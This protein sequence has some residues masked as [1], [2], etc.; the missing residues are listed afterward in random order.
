M[1]QVTGAEA[2]INT[3]KAQGV[4]HIF[5]LPGTTVVPLLDALAGR[6][7]VKYIL[8]LHE[9]SVMSMAEGYARAT[10]GP[11]F[12]SI[13]MIPGTAN[14]LGCMYSAQRDGVPLVVLATDQ[15]SRISGRDTFTETSDMVEINN[16][17]TKWS[18]CV[19]RAERIPEAL[20]R[21]FK[22]AAAQPPGPVYLTMP[23]NLLAEK[24]EYGNTALDG[25]RLSTRLEP[26]PEQI[27]NAAR[28]LLSA[29]RPISVAGYGVMTDGALEE[30]VELAEL[31]AMPVYMEPF[32]PYLTFPHRHELFF[33][34]YRPNAPVQESAD[35]M[36]GVGGR[37]FVEFDYSPTP[38]IPE[39]LRLIHMNV[40]PWEVGKI[41]PT[42]V[43][44][45]A[46]AKSGLA[47]L[48]DGV[49]ELMDAGARER[50]Q[51]RSEHLRERKK[52]KDASLAQELKN[53]W[54]DAPLKQWRMTADLVQ[55]MGE[56]TVLVNES[57]TASGYFFDYPRQELYFANSCGF[58]GW[59]LGA[60]VG[61]KLA[62]PER[63]V[64][65]CVGDG[66]FVLGMQ[67]LWSSMRYN[68]PITV[69]VVNNGTYVAVK[70]ALNLHGGKAAQQP[71]TLGLGSDLGSPD[72]DYAKIAE[73][74]G[75][76]G[77]RV[78]KPEQLRPAIRRALDADRLAVVDVLVDPRETGYGRPRLP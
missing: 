38:M 68:L 46:D 54:D 58:L 15:D 50:I 1:A 27:H 53:G 3:L 31:L 18:W 23:K 71:D 62:M 59:G 5:G 26:D 57:V 64:V 70:G 19:P 63:K 77:E 45:V 51:L 35:L 48:I 40:D 7:D 72:V 43:G 73:G 60:A 78:E 28:Y 33:G 47:A 42:E 37:L 29:E 44:I 52:E 61:V 30:M 74:F 14:A 10:G 20:N 75:G 22:T 17:F 21:A 9:N 66:S 65:A 34:P 25:Q 2:L 13:H 36:F 8:S 56:E 11:A 24:I 4:Q 55:E 67:S 76:V 6:E 69:V 41:F 49:K 12:V 39:G 32:H 16:Q